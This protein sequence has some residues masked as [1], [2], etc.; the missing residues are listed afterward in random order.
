MK[1][2]HTCIVIPQHV[3]ATKILIDEMDTN[4]SVEKKCTPEVPPVPPTNSSKKSNQHNIESA[5]QV[6]PCP[7]NAKIAH[8]ILQ[9]NV[10]Q[11]QALTPQDVLAC[12]QRG[13][14]RF[15]SGTVTVTISMI[16]FR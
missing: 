9:P 12:L 3:F 4:N 5:K 8:D 13:N 2:N 1:K 16:P 14:T 11:S 7:G 6:Q 10:M 15:Y